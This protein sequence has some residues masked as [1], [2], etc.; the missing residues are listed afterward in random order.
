MN[1]RT[2]KLC[3]ALRRRSFGH[4]AEIVDAVE[5]DPR[6][7]WLA[8]DSGHIHAVAALEPDDELWLDVHRWCIASGVRI[9]DIPKRS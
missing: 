5:R 1:S 9:V 8:L 7:N 4:L 2:A 3:A 6:R